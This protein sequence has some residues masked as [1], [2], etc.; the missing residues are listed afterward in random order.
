MW[1]SGNESTCNA[2][3]VDLISELGR[4]PGGG[5]GN[6]LQYSCLKNPMDQRA[7]KGGRVGHDWSDLACTYTALVTCL[8]SKM[9]FKWLLAPPRLGH[10]KLCS[11]CLAV[12]RQS[13]W[14]PQAAMQE[15][16][17]PR[18]FSAVEARCGCSS[19]QSVQPCSAFQPSFLR[20]KIVL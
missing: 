15:S 19:W 2:G 16:Q 20:Y 6:P 17:L 7:S 1:L 14:L 18:D 11:I 9:Q 13:L 8:T 5:K 12:L 10:K 3:D 4:S